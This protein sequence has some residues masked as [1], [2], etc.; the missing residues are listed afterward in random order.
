MKQTL[1]D[2]KKDLEQLEQAL[3][4]D[5]EYENL[6]DNSAMVASLHRK[7]TNF[8]QDYNSILL[9]SKV[10]S[11]NKKYLTNKQ[12]ER[13]A[14]SYYLRKE[15]AQTFAVISNVLGVSIPRAR[16]LFI[17]AQ[18]KKLYVL[19]KSNLEE[20]LKSIR[21]IFE[22]QSIEEL[23]EE[24][25]FFFKTYENNRG[26]ENIYR[27]LLADFESN[28]KKEDWHLKLLRECYLL[29]EGGNTFTAIANHFKITTCEVKDLY[30]YATLLDKIGKLK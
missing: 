19:A 30:E 1:S 8:Q 5:I 15:K 23:I 21:E 11:F 13:I 2:I 14:V 6:L 9:E 22:R 12:D 29:K 18:R 20:T 28:K 16:D 7:I 24:K 10:K 17:A 3:N 26:K 4:S 25:R 27:K